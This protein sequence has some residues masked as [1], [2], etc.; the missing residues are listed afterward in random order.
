MSTLN[1]KSVVIFQTALDYNHIVLTHRLWAD[2]QSFSSI[3]DNKYKILNIQ[4]SIGFNGWESMFIRY[5]LWSK[6][7]LGESSNAKLFLIIITYY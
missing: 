5:D 6:G 4:S 2:F 1:V 7:D 3:P